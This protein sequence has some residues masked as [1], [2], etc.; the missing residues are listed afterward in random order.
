MN[1][2]STI[3]LVKIIPGSREET[4]FIEVLDSVGVNR[5]NVLC[6]LGRLFRTEYDE[7]IISDGL[8]KQIPK[9]IENINHSYSRR[10]H[11][12]L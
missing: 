10:K 9:V 2:I 1:D 3:H 5:E 6:R 12:T 7:Y 11:T 4:R 8:Y